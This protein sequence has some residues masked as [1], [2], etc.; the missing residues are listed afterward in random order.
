VCDC[1]GEPCKKCG[2]LFPLHLEDFSTGRHEIMLV[3]SRCMILLDLYE[4]TL[5]YKF[6][7]TKPYVEF[8]YRQDDKRGCPNR[9]FNLYALTQNAW[10]HRQGNTPNADHRIVNTVD[11]V[12]V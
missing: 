11:V 1:Y 10:N 5:L 2:E 8:A 6:L 4:D 3:C 9:Y 7:K 12:A